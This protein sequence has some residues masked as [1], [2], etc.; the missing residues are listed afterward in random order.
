MAERD[1]FER[2]L[3]Q[4]TLLRLLGLGLAVAGLWVAGT[5]PLGPQS[6]FAGLGLM[7]AGAA[8]VTFAPRLF[9]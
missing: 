2:R 5:S 3:W 8:L 9:R 1:P 6:P 4:M 7:L